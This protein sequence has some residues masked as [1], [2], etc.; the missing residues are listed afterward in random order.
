MSLQGRVE[1][2]VVVFQNGPPL[3]DGTLVEV[4]P[5]QPHRPGPGPKAVSKE[6][7]EALLGLIGMWKV[8]HPPSDEEVKRIVEEERLKK[9]G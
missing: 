4:T 1:N 5:L 9:Y 6:Q 7:R 8:E 2:G 3:P